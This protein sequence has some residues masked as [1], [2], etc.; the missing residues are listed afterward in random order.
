MVDTVKY[1]AAKLK[2][3]GM[4]KQKEEGLFS[5]RLRVLAG[6]LNAEHMHALA[7]LA[8][9]YGRGHI[10]LTTRQGVEIPHVDY[11]DLEALQ[12]E[13]A[14]VGIAVGGTGPRVRTI[15]ACQ[16]GSCRYGQIDPQDLAVKIHNRVNDFE[17]L[18]HKF[19]ITVSGCPNSCTKPSENDLGV[20]GVA[21]KRLDEDLCTAC[22]QCVKA[23]P[24]KGVLELIDGRL[25]VDNQACIACGRC[26]KACP[27][28]AWESLGSAY[29]VFVGGKMG[30]QPRPADRLALEP[31]DE[32]TLLR[33]IEAVMQWYADHGETR[34]RFGTTIDRVG[35]QGLVDW[36]EQQP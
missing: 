30:R 2:A 24:V 1:D 33:L 13:L 18:P 28:Q 8:E 36:V 22:G 17:G 29:A 21:R 7:E 32:E 35:L 4:M 26:I 11:D 9:R 19:K 3:S 23:C 34:E 6:R 20:M 15:T 10:H 5:V 27:T 12:K 16:G 25:V 31:S 14:Q